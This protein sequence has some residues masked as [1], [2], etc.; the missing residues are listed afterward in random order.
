MCKTRGHRRTYLR[1][2][3]T[4]WSMAMG[5]MSARPAPAAI[6]SLRVPKRL[7]VR[8]LSGRQLRARDK[9]Q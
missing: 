1:F 6:L 5:S 3:L 8:R 4:D 9:S 7:P 2:N